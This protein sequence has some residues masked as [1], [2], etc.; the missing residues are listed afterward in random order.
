MGKP[1]PKKK[2]K[3]ARTVTVYGAYSFIDKDP[4]I[5]EVRTIIQRELGGLT[6]VKLAEVQEL[7]GPKAATLKRWFFGE[8]RRPTNP[9]VEAAGRA[10]GYHRSWVKMKK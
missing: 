5:D 7:G 9:A 6:S 10:L 1:Q 3:P 2:F 4:V 8:T